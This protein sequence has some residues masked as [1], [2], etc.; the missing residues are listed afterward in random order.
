MAARL[1]N[2]SGDILLSVAVAVDQ[3]L[4]TLGLLVRVQSLALDILDQRELGG[5]RFID[6]AHDSRDRV[7][8]G[9]LRRAPAAFAGN[10]LKT[11]AVAVRPEQDRLKHATL[12][13]RIG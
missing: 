9:P 2:D 5:G 6:L 4:V 11:F 3:L 12:D 1:V 7:Q 10:D 8:P 13:D